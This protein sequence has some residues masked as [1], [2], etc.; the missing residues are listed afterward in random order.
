[1]NCC[2]ETEKRALGAYANQELPFEKLVEESIPK[3]V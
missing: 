2:G 3:E 1:M